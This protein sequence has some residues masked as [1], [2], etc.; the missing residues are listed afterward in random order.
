MFL[1]RITYNRNYEVYLV[2]KPTLEFLKTTALTLEFV[3]SFGKQHHNRLK[4][5]DKKAIIFA[6]A[7]YV[8]DTTLF[9]L[10]IEYCQLPYEIYRMT[11]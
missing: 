3:Q 4:A 8:D 5:K 1:F 7:K 9:N 2:Y 10:R 6:P 11:K